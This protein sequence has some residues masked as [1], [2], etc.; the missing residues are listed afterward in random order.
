MSTYTTDDPLDHLTRPSLLDGCYEPRRRTCNR[1]TIL[2]GYDQDPQDSRYSIANVERLELLVKALRLMEQGHGQRRVARWLTHVTQRPIH[3]TTL[4]H[5][6]NVERN[7][8]KT[9][10]HLRSATENEVASLTP[11]AIDGVEMGSV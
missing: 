2:F 10:K 9:R 6:Y 3:H 1:G 4:R 11:A 7:I 8:S 5:R